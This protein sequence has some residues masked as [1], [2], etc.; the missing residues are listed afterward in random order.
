MVFTSCC[1]PTG[2]IVVP[3]DSLHLPH[4]VALGCKISLKLSQ[5][6]TT[7]SA[8][9]LAPSGME[10][11][12]C[13][14]HV[15]VSERIRQRLIRCCRRQGRVLSGSQQWLHLQLISRE[16][17][18]QQETRDCWICVRMDLPG[19][20]AISALTATSLTTGAPLTG[21][22]ASLPNYYYY[23]IS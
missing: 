8:R 15:K 4:K 19:L 1:S 16:S 9:H 23:V 3:I 14:W 20:Y 5:T 17:Q 13:Y 22:G 2:L 6:S 10:Y 18:S 7:W 12:W 11:E 21:S